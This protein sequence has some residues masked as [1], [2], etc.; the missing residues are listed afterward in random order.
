MAFPANMY[1]YIS[2][3]EI[4]PYEVRLAAFNKEVITFGRAEDN[5]IILQSKFASRH[6]G[7][8]YM[9]NGHVKI[10][11]LPDSTNGLFYH[12]KKIVSTAL[13]DGTYIR[14]MG[15]NN[16]EYGVLFVCS[17]KQQNVVWNSIPLKGKQSI[18]IG[19]DPRN[20]IVLDHISV[21]HQ[22]AIIQESGGNYFIHDNGS[23]NG[24]LVNG[25][26]VHGRKQLREKDIILITNSKLVYTGGEIVYNVARS[27]IS[28]EAQHVVKQVGKNNLTICNDVC[29]NINPGELVAI[30]GG[31]GA[32]KTSIMNCI[33]GYTPPTG[34][35]VL[36]NDV[37]LY[38]NYAALKNIIGY[39]PQQD[40][41][42]DNLTVY[43]ML[44][45]SARLRLP[46]DVSAEEIDQIVLKVIDTVELSH[47]KDAMVR[48]LS[49]GQKK[50]ASIA[51]ELL[52]DPNLFFLDE[53][54]SGLDPGTERN[55][56]RTLKGMTASGKTV[57]L[58]THSTLALPEYDKIVF[59]G[60]GGK[61]CFAGSYQEALKFFGT[62]DIV[63]VYEM[64]TENPDFWR[65]RFNQYR[66]DRDAGIDN[67][68]GRTAISTSTKK[69]YFRQFGVLTG[70][71][72][73]LLLNDKQRMLLLLLQ[74][75]LLAVL[76]SLV[77]DEDL[78]NIYETTNNILFALSCC[79]FWVGI[80]SAIQEICKERVI[81]KREYMTGL[82][83]GSYILSKIFVLSLLCI[84]QGL[85]IIGALVIVLKIKIALVYD[86]SQFD[87]GYLKA[88][89][90]TNVLLPAF[91][92]FAITTILSSMSAAAMGIFV[93]ALF[94]NADRAM[95]VAPIL[96][97]PQILF[98][99]LLF[100][101][102]GAISI[103]SYF[104][105][106]R[107]SME[108]YG[109]TVDLGNLKLR[110]AEKMK[111]AFIGIGPPLENEQM[112]LD[113]DHSAFIKMDVAHKATDAVHY[114]TSNE[115]LLMV[116]GIMLAFVL[117]FTVMARLVLVTNI[118]K[119]ERS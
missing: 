5:D 1:L 115:H 104:V 41:V 34:G 77:A 75:P 37:D 93:S 54:T 55:L 39:V 84:I 82:N 50:R 15:N 116:W 90:S 70:R 76:I 59:M 2:D 4:K 30:I 111:D 97:M 86:A 103:V 102:E 83:L 49:G 101:L 62:D 35:V 16:Q 113:F 100:E 112:G 32:G 14:I 17:I 22:H 119:D 68:V 63:N 72:I 47:R 46:K 78:F 27:G 36:V 89:C 19:R 43:D 73:H 7:C 109:A 28:V 91:L 105:V 95:T 44:K 45:Y 110:S 87:D 23:T 85:I 53:P 10:E 65:D 94:T 20:D 107:W 13:R 12:G 58:V 117:I 96:L 6:H 88:M 71:Y 8:I 57:I 24:V 106:C 60:M 114:A 38:A 25:E 67:T 56:V 18:S 79:A 69:G 80:L 21:S 98:S 81:L 66:T 31:S 48:S 51:V 108:G 74:A 64:I 92:E 33:S 52:T 61:L 3:G 118:K 9:E 29:L 42:Y 26:R 99:G 11:N 40:I